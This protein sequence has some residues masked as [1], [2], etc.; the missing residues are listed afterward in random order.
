[1]TS[2]QAGQF[3]RHRKGQ[4]SEHGNEFPGFIK[5]EEFL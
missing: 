5:G 1:M 4:K 2:A 3:M